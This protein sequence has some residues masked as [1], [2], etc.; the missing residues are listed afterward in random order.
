ML[1]VLATFFTGWTGVG[2]THA[3]HGRFSPKAPQVI[4]VNDKRL[5]PAPILQRWDRGSS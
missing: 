3:G 1:S 2:E 4:L 5:D